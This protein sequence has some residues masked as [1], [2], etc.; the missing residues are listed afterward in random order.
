MTMSYRVVYKVD[1]SKVGHADYRVDTVNAAYDA[2][3]VDH[4]DEDVVYIRPLG[5][6][7]EEKE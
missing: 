7:D 4:K 2:F 6:D 5:P 3:R 1:D